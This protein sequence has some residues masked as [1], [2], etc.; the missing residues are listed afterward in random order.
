MHVVTGGRVIL[1]HGAARREVKHHIVPTSYLYTLS[2]ASNHATRLPTPSN[3]PQH[4]A[5]QRSLHFARANR[6]PE[7]E[8]PPSALTSWQ[9]HVHHRA[10]QSR[11]RGAGGAARAL[12][13]RAAP[14]IHT[15]AS[16][17]CHSHGA[18]THDMLP[19]PAAAARTRAPA[20]QCE[21]KQLLHS[22]RAILRRSRS[23]QIL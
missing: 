21:H 23:Q 9:R 7:N 19:P 4:A 3:H 17:S 13:A 22:R 11:R 10:P 2:P 20:T 6:T 18:A 8:F 14:R 1:H 12:R 5:H 16:A 15:P